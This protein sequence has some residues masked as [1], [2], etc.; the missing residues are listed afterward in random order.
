MTATAALPFLTS[1][2]L[3]CGGELKLRTA[4]FQVEEVPA[5]LPCGEGEHLFLWI[6]KEN[7]SAEQLTQHLARSLRVSR[8]DIGVAGLKDRVAV[9]R[10]WVSVPG[11]AK[12]R[13]EEASTASVRILKQ[14][15]HRNKLKTGHLKGNR[16]TI[17]LRNVHPE[18]ADVLPQL[19][20]EI[21]RS[22][23][24]NYFGDQRFGKEGET[25]DLGMRLLRGAATPQ[26][27]PFARR[28]FLLRLALS[29]VQ[30]MLFNEV[31]AER[32][33]DGSLNTVRL[34]DVM[35]VSA[36]GGVFLVDDPL[37]DQARLETGEILPTGP[38]FGPKM[39]APTGRTSE[40][41]QH[42][43]ASHD[44]TMEHFRKFAKLTS[45]TRR[46]LLLRSVDLQGEVDPAE[47]SATLQ[48]T[49]PAGAY[50]TVLLRE[51]MKQNQ[52]GDATES[53]SED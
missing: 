21:D 22:G 5:Y 35:E 10:Q 18:A 45:G 37:A 25:L 53:T 4:D 49:L 41:E 1:S 30:S 31:L 28:K 8:Q 27:I 34:G 29:A 3:H 12:D 16:F 52:I 23:V 26:E 40:L 13:V 19:L 14:Q 36:S 48:F 39:K 50:A 51:I 20:R 33:R 42:V 46:S 38:L 43:L 32:L 47:R 17:V 9:T 24:P 15:W 7:V 11:S 44:L 6:E 2:H